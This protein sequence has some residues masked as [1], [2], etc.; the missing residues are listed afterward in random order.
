MTKNLPNGH[1]IYEMAVKRPYNILSSS[2]GRPSKIYPKL[3][4]LFENIPSGNPGFGG[5]ANLSTQKNFH[6][7]HL[8]GGF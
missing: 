2:N 8:Y 6:A 7:L 1:T 4:F 3:G 5:V